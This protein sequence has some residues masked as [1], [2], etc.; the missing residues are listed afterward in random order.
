[1]TREMQGGQE[2]EW[3][4]AGVAAQVAAASLDSKPWP[5]HSEGEGG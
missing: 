2:A 1:M 4:D 5:Q 3:A